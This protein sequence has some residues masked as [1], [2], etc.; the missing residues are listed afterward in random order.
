MGIKCCKDCDDR[1]P[2]CHSTC[3]RYLAEKKEHERQREVAQKQRNIHNMMISY[4]INAKKRYWKGD[5]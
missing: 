3:E 4:S 5:R 2:N 1:H